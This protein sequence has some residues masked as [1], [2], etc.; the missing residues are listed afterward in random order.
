MSGRFRTA[1]L[2]VFKKFARPPDLLSDRGFALLFVRAPLGIGLLSP[3]GRIRAVNPKAQTLLGVE[4][5]K[6]QQVFS[7][8]PLTR[9]LS[10]E[11]LSDFFKAKKQ[12]LAAIPSAAP[13]ISAYV[14][15]TVLECRS[16]CLPAIPLEISLIPLGAPLV[17]FLFLLR[18]VSREH[19]VRARATELAR[20]EAVA[21]LARG[22]AHDF[23]NLLAGIRGH[24]QILQE[25]PKSSPESLEDIVLNC[26]RGEA[27]VRRL[28]EFSHD[29]ALSAPAP[30]EVAPAKA[31]PAKAAPA[32]IAPAKAMARDSEREA[33][34]NC[35]LGAALRDIVPLLRRLLGGLVVLEL[36]VPSEVIISRIAPDQFEQII[37]NLAINARDALEAEG[38]T[39]FLR[40]RTS[41]HEQKLRVQ[42]EVLPPGE[43][44][45][46][47][48]A[49]T[50]KGIEE[51]IGR[52]IFDP[53]FTT[54]GGTGLGLA[55]VLALTRRAGGAINVHSGENTAPPAGETPAGET[56]AGE[57]PAGETPA[58]ERDSF[59]GD[60][61]Q[62]SVQKKGAHFDIWLPR[63]FETPLSRRAGK[64]A[65]FSPVSVS[66]KGERIVIVDDDD[67]IL[68]VARHALDK[69]GFIVHSFG[70]AH[71][72]LEFIA[73]N[74][75]DL[76][77][78]D[79]RMPSMSGEALIRAVHGY[80][81]R[82]PVLVMTGHGSP[83]ET[84]F[85]VIEKPFD[86]DDLRARC[87]AV[88][89]AA[90]EVNLQTSESRSIDTP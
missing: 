51:S 57:T 77:V 9:W 73:C 27:L 70:D 71:R 37:V 85:P 60:A 62:K 84:H 42:E 83:D 81:P 4:K 52:H 30:T 6:Q 12:G 25:N 21:R 5:E 1:L 74:C 44:A 3:S 61:R 32:E 41:R 69:S 34:S 82:L 80:W 72:A 87:L 23:N 19:S 39:I 11:S 15:G 17:G 26:T 59:Q 33:G 38:G 36:D 48:V 64:R 56:P 46:F 18:D 8:A 14:K 79:L 76:L 66:G 55:T 67:I 86:L 16:A 45:I 28:L 35:D 89:R 78:T 22:I 40:L 53:F 24:A 68:S 49:D 58:G 7:G 88:L 75:P 31:A 2:R 13:E 65:G 50:G 10:S 43:Y 29:R 90:S 47:S 63:V 20:S 54:G